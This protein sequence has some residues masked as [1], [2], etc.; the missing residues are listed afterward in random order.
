MLERYALCNFSI[1]NTDGNHHNKD[2]IMQIPTS[3][4]GPLQVPSDR[5][6]TDILP[7]SFSCPVP[8]CSSVLAGKV[9]QRSL[10]R[11]LRQPGLGRRI[12]EEKTVWVNLHKIEHD[13]LIATRAK[14]AKSKSRKK[15]LEEQK[16]SRASAFR[17]CAGRMGIT[18]M[19]MIAEKLEIWEGIWA[20]GEND[21]SIGYYA[22]V[23]LDL[24]TNP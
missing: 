2:A 4:S 12:G 24:F 22:W 11:H 18:D 16:I 14:A 10:M 1:N 7:R 5:I 21:D 13:K 17:L 15:K 8:S 23:L 6:A 19:T 9:P 20:D 3:L